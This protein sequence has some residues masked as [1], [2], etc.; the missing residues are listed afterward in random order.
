METLVSMLIMGVFFGSSL[1][2]YTHASKRAEWSG[3][4]LAAQAM[5][6]RQMEQFF[7]ATWDTQSNPPV[8]QTT[9]VPTNV[10]CV[11]DLP[12]SGTN[13]VWATNICSVSN[14]TVSTTPLVNIK[15]ITVNTYWS[16]NGA[17]YMNKVV[18]YRSPDQ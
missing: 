12:I 9:N 5:A 18:N 2:A 13:V 8:D 4:S 7:A 16:F 14:I 17:V 3:L 11:L 10:V 1:L 15:M 6:T